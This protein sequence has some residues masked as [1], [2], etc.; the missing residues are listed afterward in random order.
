MRTTKKIKEQILHEADNKCEYCGVKLDINNM[1]IDHKIPLSKGGSNDISNLAAACRSCNMVKADKII[2]SI[3]NPI[4]KQAAETWI[5]LFIKSPKATS[6]ISIIISIAMAVFINYFSNIE[7]EKRQQ[8]L[9][10]N[11]TFKTQIEQLD[12]TEKSLKQ[13]LNFINTQKSN[14]IIT[15]QSINSLKKEKENLQPLVKADRKT[16]EA[17]FSAQ[18]IRAEK[19]AN[20]EHWIGFGFGVGASLLASILWYILQYFMRVDREET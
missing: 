19:N 14:M 7:A 2:D 6:F 16:V 1:S 8:E 9:S 18:E 13:L 5:H 4:V 10:K 11:L 15:E 12:T 17:I 20:K 3:P